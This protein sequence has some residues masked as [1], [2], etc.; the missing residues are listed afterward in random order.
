MAAKR[1]GQSPIPS[2][3]GEKKASQKSKMKPVQG[4]SLQV[5]SLPRKIIY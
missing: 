5:N 4:T 3:L 2:N 1:N